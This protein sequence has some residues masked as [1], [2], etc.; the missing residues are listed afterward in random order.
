[1]TGSL[2][3]MCSAS[4]P[5]AIQATAKWVARKEND[6]GYQCEEFI[7]PVASWKMA[8]ATS[9]PMDPRSAACR[10]RCLLSLGGRIQNR[11]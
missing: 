9:N 5:T 7:K 1:M 4:A 6:H 3:A 11:G 8:A 2:T 10:A